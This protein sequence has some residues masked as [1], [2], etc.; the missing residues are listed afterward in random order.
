MAQ[1]VFGLR[2]G[3][4]VRF[5]IPAPNEIIF[6]GIRWGRH[7]EFFTPAYWASQTL[8]AGLQGTDHRIGRTL[9]EE[10]AACLLGGHGIPAEIGLA[11]FMH[12]RSLGMLETGRAPSERELH[13]AL[14]QPLRRG[15]RMVRYRFARQKAS[16]LSPV[17]RALDYDDPFLDNDLAFRNWFL[18]FKGIGPK[19]ASWIA[20]NWLGSN[21]VAILDIHIHRAGL[22]CGIFSPRQTI[23]RHYFEMER[24]FI[25]FANAMDVSP[26]H[27]DAVIWT[28]MKEAGD[29]VFSLVREVPSLAA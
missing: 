8:I 22:I 4:A 17:L 11:A 26:S 20:R 19:T 1:T 18:A 29:S 23:S 13:E 27:L 10:V 24:Q 21:N 6:D 3:K 14:S 9:N 25:R 2:N 5:S 16:Y 12:L 15:E 28:Q 7:E